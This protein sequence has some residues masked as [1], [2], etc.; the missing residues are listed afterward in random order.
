[1]SC[2]EKL[3]LNTAL[4]KSIDKTKATTLRF[5]AT[6][7]YKFLKEVTVDV[8]VQRSYTETEESKG[9]DD[10]SKDTTKTKV[11]KVSSEQLAM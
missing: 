1:M 10:H 11:M 6:T 2:F 8:P 3:G 5:D 4:L 7:S 9:S